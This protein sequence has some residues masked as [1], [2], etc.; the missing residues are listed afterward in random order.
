MTPKSE[1]PIEASGM[2]TGHESA[3][4]NCCTCVHSR[5][6]VASSGRSYE[7]HNREAQNLRI[8]P[9]MPPFIRV[10]GF[11]DASRLW[12]TY[13]SPSV[14]TALNTSYR[15]HKYMRTQTVMG[16]KIWFDRECVHVASDPSSN[17]SCRLPACSCGQ[18][19]IAQSHLSSHVNAH[20]PGSG[21][22]K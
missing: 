13:I 15:F 17:A 9:I 4:L 18:R 5:V 22:R 11:R 21:H 12:T 19:F 3:T 7:T 20:P 1:A 2:S 10:L 6:T 16:G 14:G 8:S